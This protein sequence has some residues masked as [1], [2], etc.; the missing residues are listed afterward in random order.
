[1]VR[2]PFRPHRGEKLVARNALLIGELEGKRRLEGRHANAIDDMGSGIL[3][4]A[5]FAGA[6]HQLQLE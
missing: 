4:R 6:R 3:P 1:M 5:A 2:L